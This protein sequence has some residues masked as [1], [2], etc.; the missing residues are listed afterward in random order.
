MARY[1]QIDGKLARTAIA[2][3]EYKQSKLDE[4]SMLISQVRNCL[5]IMIKNKGLTYS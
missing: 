4:L 5:Y 1:F 3:G 2:N